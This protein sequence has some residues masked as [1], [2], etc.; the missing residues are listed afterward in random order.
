MRR[1]IRYFVVVCVFLWT[2]M[3]IVSAQYDKD[4]FYMRGRRALAD[5]KYALAIENF[6]ILAQLDTSDYWNYFFRGIAK[7]NLGD[8]R[9]AKRDFDR[10]VRI[11]PVFTSG[12]HYRGITESRFGDYDA[13]LE[14]LQKAIELRPGNV[15]IYFSRGVTYFLSQRFDK[16]V[17]DFDKYISVIPHSWIPYLYTR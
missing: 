6:N 16:A 17:K 5:G 12:Y 2:G 14:N 4:A 11:N 10:S 15:S 1:V 7:Y 8:L 9:G 13:A 3:Q